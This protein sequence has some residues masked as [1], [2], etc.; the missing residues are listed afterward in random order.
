MMYKEVSLND[1]AKYSHWVRDI[2]LNENLA[3]REKTR[4]EVNREFNVE[5]W[6]ALLRNINNM[7]PSL[8]NLLK[9]SYSNESLV[10][11]WMKDR[12]ILMS[13]SEAF[14]YQLSLISKTIETYFSGNPLVDL[15]A[16][17]GSIILSLAKGSFSKSNL[18]AC[19]YTE[20]GRELIKTIAKAEGIN[21]TVA[22]CDFKSQDIVNI[23]LPKD[24]VVFTSYS[25]HYVRKY[26]M[27]FIQSM[28]RLRPNVVINFEP[29]YEFYD[30]STIMGLLR[31]K[32]TQVN[33]YNTNYVTVL[34]EAESNK[35]IRILDI[36]ANVFGSNPLLPM[37]IIVWQPN[38]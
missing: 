28:K 19:E 18:V 12:I 25:V 1:L 9:L 30:D 8:D 6:G 22:E 26:Q 3:I 15:G 16:G 10:P 20:S 14:S 27:D 2:I 13:G 38:Y 4:S 11:V 17:S 23:E 36:Q 37:S 24:S 33:D 34:K 31:R 32:Y 29:C 35:E 21:I 5:K 7:H